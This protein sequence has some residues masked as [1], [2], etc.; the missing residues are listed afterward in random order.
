M[1]HRKKS[2]AKFWYDKYT[3]CL[4]ANYSFRYHTKCLKEQIADLQQ[5]NNRLR[6]RLLLAQ[7]GVLISDKEGI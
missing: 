7:K 3:E 1:A 2:K 5:E 4:K 6:M